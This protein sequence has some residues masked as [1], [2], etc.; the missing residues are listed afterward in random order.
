MIFERKF[1]ENIVP[2]VSIFYI[3]LERRKNRRAAMEQQF[4]SLGLKAH[5]VVACDGNLL[6]DQQSKQCD[7]SKRYSRFDA[8][9]TNNE[10]AC[11]LSHKDV[12]LQVKKTNKPALILEDDVFISDEIKTILKDLIQKTEKIDFV[13]FGGA[14]IRPALPVCRLSPNRV[15]YLMTSGCCGSHAYFITPEGAGELLEATQTFNVAVDIFLDYYWAQK[16]AT[17]AILPW[18]ITLDAEAQYSTI[19][20]ERQYLERR[21]RKSYAANVSLRRWMLR[22]RRSLIKFGWGIKAL[23]LWIFKKKI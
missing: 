15:L 23:S 10:I 6:S 22:Q 8:A 18:P 5:R 20:S 17:Y 2:T 7:Q 12:W 3:N 14:R 1:P 11:F 19:G 4:Q 13:R 16:G 9:M 21:I